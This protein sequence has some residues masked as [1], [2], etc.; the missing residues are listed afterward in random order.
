MPKAVPPSTTESS[1][2][3]PYARRNLEGGNHLFEKSVFNL[4]ELQLNYERKPQNDDLHIF[5]RSARRENPYTNAQARIELV[6]LR[7]KSSLTHDFIS[8]Y[9]YW[10]L[11]P[12]L[13]VPLKSQHPRTTR[14]KVGRMQFDVSQAKSRLLELQ[15][16]NSRLEQALPATLK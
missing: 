8:S 12:E 10:P 1:T 5:S 2:A 11:A 7:R 3:H 4:T 9:G 15:R 6:S 14:N 13:L 16:I